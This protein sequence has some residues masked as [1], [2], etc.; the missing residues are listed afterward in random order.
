MFPSK[1]YTN[2]K[3][4]SNNKWKTQFQ[5]VNRLIPTR[6]NINSKTAQLEVTSSRWRIRIMSKFDSFPIRPTN[7]FRKTT[8]VK[9]HT[10]DVKY[11]QNRYPGILCSGT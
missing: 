3:T 9:V 6:M 4:T 10:I 8:L 2:A 7:L 11:Q 1:I 5:A